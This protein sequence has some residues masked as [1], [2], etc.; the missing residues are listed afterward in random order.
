MPEEKMVQ[1]RQS[2]ETKLC[3]VDL[4]RLPLLVC[5]VTASASI[6]YSGVLLPALQS[7]KKAAFSLNSTSTSRTPSIHWTHTKKY[8]A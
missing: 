4:I 6:V 2:R 1:E 7:D 5:C 8:F 3:G